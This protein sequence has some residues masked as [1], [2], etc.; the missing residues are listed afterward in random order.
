MLYY[1]GLLAGVNDPEVHHLF[2]S[3]THPTLVY[4]R[5]LCVSHVPRQAASADLLAFVN[6]PVVK[7]VLPKAPAIPVE[8]SLLPC[9]FLCEVQTAAVVSVPCSH[10][11]PPGAAGATAAAPA[12]CVCCVVSSKTSFSVA[13]A[14]LDVAHFC[15]GSAFSARAAH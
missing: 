7:P 14:T 5:N 10:I 1:I 4:Q 15:K 3:P 6:D 11:V 8:R 12:L 13:D 2:A 9:F